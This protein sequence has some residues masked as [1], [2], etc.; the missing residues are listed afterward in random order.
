LPHRAAPEARL[1]WSRA[2]DVSVLT[3]SVIGRFTSDREPEDWFVVRNVGSSHCVVGGPLRGVRIDLLGGE[4]ECGNEVF[5]FEI[6]LT[7]ALPLQLTELARYSRWWKGQPLSYPPVSNMT[8]R[9]ILILRTIDAL[10]EGA[11]LRAIGE[12]LVRGD[13]WPGPGESTKS[14]SRRLVEAAKSMWIDDPR[15]ILKSSRL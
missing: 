1:L 13:D 2:D 6:A 10:G 9:R 12:H 11:S 5:R 15:S 8:K 14:C 4:P 7:P 3:A